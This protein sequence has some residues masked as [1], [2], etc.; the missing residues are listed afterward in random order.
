MAVKALHLTSHYI[1]LNLRTC[2][3]SLIS[4]PLNL[5][6][7]A[8]WGDVGLCSTTHRSTRCLRWEQGGKQGDTLR[9]G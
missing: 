2:W 9:S 8:M 3:V 7:V 4:K 5:E 6:E 1:K